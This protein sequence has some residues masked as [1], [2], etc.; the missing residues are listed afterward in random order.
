M[1]NIINYR[2]NIKKITRNVSVIS[3]N[4][5]NIVYNKLIKVGIF[6]KNYKL[7]REFENYN[8]LIN[9]NHNLNIEKIDNLQIFNNI[10]LNTDINL[11]IFYLNNYYIETSILFD[12]NFINEYEELDVN[13]N[14]Y[15][16]LIFLIGDY[17]I[18]H[19]NLHDLYYRLNNDYI[20]C[21]L[22]FDTLNNYDFINKNYNFFHCDFKLSNIT[23]FNNII[24]LTNQISNN[25]ISNNQINY[26]SNIKTFLLDFEFGIFVNN[27]ELLTVTPDTL[28]NNYLRLNYPLKINTLF[29][30][31]FDI[32]VFSLSQYY[33]LQNKLNS[34]YLNII[35]NNIIKNNIIKL[36][37]EQLSYKI[38]YIFLNYMIITKVKIQPIFFNLLCSYVNINKFYYALIND[39][40]FWESNDSLFNNVLIII[41]KNLLFMEL[42]NK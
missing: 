16:E 14:N 40:I 6:S 4:I 18:D 1:I 11:K 15:F 41:K 19:I 38:F 42:N 17:K 22:T 8:K 10:L 30:Y 27:N 13:I 7:K 3:F 12:I 26:E 34:N 23:T 36:E 2:E 5:N 24:E 21:K 28:I 25:Q 9:Y 32:Y 29:L 37:Y 20:K 39:N 35:K 33:C 31:L